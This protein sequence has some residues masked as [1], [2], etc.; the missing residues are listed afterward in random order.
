[1]RSIDTDIFFTPQSDPGMLILTSQSP[2]LASPNNPAI[3]LQEQATR[4]A[5]EGHYLDIQL[6]GQR[7]PAL[8]LE[9]TPPDG[10]VVAITPFNHSMQLRTDTIHRFAAAYWKRRALPD[11]RITPYR[12]RNLRQM[13]QV[14]DG[15]GAGASYR[16]IA[17]VMFN[18]GIV[19]AAQWKTMP[20]RDTVMRRFREGRKLVAGGYRELLFQS[21]STF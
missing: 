21:R 3:V 8:F 9:S 15:H 12:T 20:E 5:P 4:E 10:P 19:T 16:K 18:T 6:A 14:L 7:F 1:M 17:E 2:V 13:L 11:P